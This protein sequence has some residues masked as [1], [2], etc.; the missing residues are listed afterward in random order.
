VGIQVISTSK[1]IVFQGPS[2]VSLD[3]KGR[4]A[5]PTR[6]R[7]ALAANGGNLLTITKDPDGCLLVYPRPQWE[8]FRE[9]LQ[10]LPM[11]A[12][13]WKRIYLGNAVE[14][15]MDAHGRVLI[16]PELRESANITKEAMLTG[17]GQHFELWDKA[18][19]QAYEAQ[20]RHEPKP[21]S[22]QAFVI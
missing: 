6:Y 17:Q 21:Q 14:V 8:A 9:R 22:L 5:I 15:E 7:E 13:R 18:T 2:S 11:D 10:A 4:I 20:T 16:A 1:L 19:L 12:Q 3:A